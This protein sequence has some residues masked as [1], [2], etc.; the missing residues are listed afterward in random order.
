MKLI[1]FITLT[2]ISIIPFLGFRV[3]YYIP[4][5]FNID[6]DEYILILRNWRDDNDSVTFGLSG[7]TFLIEREID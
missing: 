3:V 4:E 7:G 5:S 2:A 6:N 1:K